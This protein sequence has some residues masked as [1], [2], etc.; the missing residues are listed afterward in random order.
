M[1]ISL[2]IMKINKYYYR[3]YTVY[4]ITNI[5]YCFDYIFHRVFNGIN[6]LV[7]IVIEM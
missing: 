3:N 6:V 2:S 7:V 5:H 1:D 4:S